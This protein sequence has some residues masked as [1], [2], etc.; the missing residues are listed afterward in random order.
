MA[1]AS[2]YLSKTLP[3]IWQR[4]VLDCAQLTAHLPKSGRIMDIG[5]GAGLPGVIL[6]LLTE[7]EVHLVRSGVLDSIHTHCLVKPDVRATI[8]HA[9]LKICRI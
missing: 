8:H 7:N 4:H 6:A 9:R 3:H 1:S 2:I 5:A